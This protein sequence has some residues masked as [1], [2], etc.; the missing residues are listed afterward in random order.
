MYCENQNC[1]KAI[2]PGERYVAIDRHIEV[3]AKPNLVDRIRGRDE[4]V[5][6]ENAELIAAYR[7]GCE[8]PR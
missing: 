7:V 5:K 2:R 3:S 1:R 6:V 8:P 4:V